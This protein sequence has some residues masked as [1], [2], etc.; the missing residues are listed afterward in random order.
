MVVFQ[1]VG[2]LVVEFGWVEVYDCGVEE[3]C[4]GVR[5]LVVFGW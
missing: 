2:I 4:C 1:W 5:R 3:A